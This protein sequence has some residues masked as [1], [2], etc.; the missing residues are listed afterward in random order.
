MPATGQELEAILKSTQ[1]DGLDIDEGLG[2]FANNASIYLRIISTFVKSVPTTIDELESY[3]TVEKL[4]DPDILQDYIVKVHGTKGSCYGIGA[5]A[6]GDSAKALEFAGKAGEV[7]T[8][9]HSTPI[10]IVHMRKLIADLK[11]LQER[12]EN[13][14]CGAAIAKAQAPDRALLAQLL[15]ATRAY[16]VE[17]MMN[18]LDQLDKQEYEQDADLVPWLR[19]QMDNFA[20]DQIEDCLTGLGL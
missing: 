11:S 2:R 20:Y 4:A 17:A 6:Q 3:A 15:A 8:I 12:I 14:D 16:D 9:I 18:I 1:I 19:N 7:E 13:G 5:N 10:F